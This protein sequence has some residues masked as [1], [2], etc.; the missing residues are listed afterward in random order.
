MRTRMAHLIREPLVH[1]LAI[2]MAFFLVWHFVGDR[3]T[4]Q[5]DRIIVTPGHI[6]RLAQQWTKTHLRPPTAQELTGLVEQ[7]I[8]E[9]VLYREAIAMGLDRDD[10]VIRKRL[11]VKMEF[12]TDD[13]TATA[14]PTDEQLQQFLIQHPEKFSVESLTSFSHVYV[15]KSQRGEKASGEAQRL[16]TL[17]NDGA[18]ADHKNL[19]DPFPLANEFGDATEADVARLFGREFPKKLSALPVGRWSGPIESGYGLHLVLVHKRTAGRPPS[20]TEVRDAVLVEW[21]LAHRRELNEIFRRQRRARYAVTVDWPEW[22]EGAV[23]AAKA[24]GDKE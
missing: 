1:F 18:V 8:D 7:E 9:E 5:P 19:G 12:L 23:A 20:L 3:I 2:G 15:N 13:V 24:T 14:T 10:L 16:L 11:A 17:L 4:K 6:E 21:R 22:A